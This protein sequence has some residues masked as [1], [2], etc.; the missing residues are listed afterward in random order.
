MSSHSSPARDVEVA[1]LSNGMRV[2]TEKMPH[3]R[4]VAVGVWVGTGS[5]AEHP[6]EIGISH[7]LEHKL[8]KGTH[9]RTAEGIAREVDSIGGNLDAFTGKELVGFNIKV[10]DEHLPIAMDILADLVLHPRFDPAD[11]EKEK[12]VILEELKMEL[13][14]PEYVVHELFTTRFWP[15][16][17]LS[18]SILGS[19]KTIQSFTIAQL[20]KYHAS[21]YVPGNLMIT[22]AGNLDHEKLIE[23]AERH[24]A[25]VKGEL[26]ELPDPAAVTALQ[27][28]E[29]N[30]EACPAN[31]KPGAPSIKPDV[32]GS[33][34]Y[35]QKV[36][37]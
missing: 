29:Q 23:L 36:N 26:P 1:R 19:R 14:N 37:K 22:A 11:L 32:K 9:T 7:F 5:R 25:G 2:I 24:F 13:D 6:K 27:F 21:I 8:F 31:W 3:V 4:S 16:H 35:F 34:E 20:A 12:S 17:P 28:F 18:K 10:L 15:N 30:G 33:K